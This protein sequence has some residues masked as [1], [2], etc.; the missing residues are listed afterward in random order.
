MHKTERKKN[1][2]GQDGTGPGRGETGR[3][4]TRRDETRRDETKRDEA[5]RG[6]NSDDDKA[7]ARVIE[8]CLLSS[9]PPSSLPTA[10]YSPRDVQPETWRLQ[11]ASNR[12]TAP[13]T[14]SSK[15]QKERRSDD[16]T[17]LFRFFYSS[18][19]LLFFSPPWFRP[20][21]FRTIAKT[22]RL[23]RKRTTISFSLRTAS[24]FFPR[25]IFFSV[26]RFGCLCRPFA[27]LSLSFS[28]SLSRGKQR[29][30]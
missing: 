6:D 19:V 8:A 15:S 13:T 23:R 24:V 18:Y 7:M 4:E 26:F 10:S 28:L 11:T 22:A 3:D 27:S 25:G 30:S 21:V 20:P 16:A 5:R 17:H 9:L 29:A 12:F 14:H 2:T 1:G